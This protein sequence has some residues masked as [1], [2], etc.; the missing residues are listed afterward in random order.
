MKL[1]SK[2]LIYE[3][4]QHL[5]NDKRLAITDSTIFVR[6]VDCKAILTGIV[7]T[8]KIRDLVE[9]ITY[10]VPQLHAVEN[11]LL[12]RELSNHRPSADHELKTKVLLAIQLNEEVAPHTISVNALQGKI[13]LEGSVTI[14]WK[15]QLAENIAYSISDVREVINR[16]TIENKKGSL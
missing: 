14:P 13:I 5:N 1:N 7:P 12:I 9:D 10:R 8:A 16:I 15:K 11:F 4:L 6:V 2:I 3:I